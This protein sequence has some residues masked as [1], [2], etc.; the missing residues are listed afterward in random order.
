[1]QACT[2]NWL[3]N[4][5]IQIGFKLA[6]HFDAPGRRMDTGSQGS[7]FRSTVLVKD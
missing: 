5:N 1:M 6:L 3:I 7:V 2:R 4:V